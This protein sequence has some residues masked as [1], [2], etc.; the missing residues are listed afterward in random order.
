MTTPSD[1]L[2]TL[3][4]TSESSK[5]Y[6]FGAVVSK[7]SSSLLLAPTS[8][9]FD[10]RLMAKAALDAAEEQ[11]QTLCASHAGTFVAVERRSRKI[12]N[13]LQ[14]LIRSCNNLIQRQ[15]VVAQ[16]KLEQ[17]D[18]GDDEDHES[19]NYVPKNLI[20]ADVDK[21]VLSLAVLSERHRV[22]RR[23]LLQHSSLI[24]LLELPSLMD[25]C[26]RSHLY[27]ESLQIAAFS[28]TLE[29][30]HGSATAST[31]S[32]DAEA[33]VLSKLDNSKDTTSIPTPSQNVV[34]QVIQQIRSR[35]NDLRRH[36]LYRLKSHITMQE[37]LEVV[38]S[39][40]RLDSID[41]ERLNHTDKEKVHKAME[42]RLQI[43]FLEARD[44]WI[45]STNAPTI[46][47]NMAA[48]NSIQRSSL[49]SAQS[50]E[51]FLDAIERYRTR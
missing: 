35:Q 27:E 33:Q 9:S 46:N 37:C 38:T 45:D 29:R 15:S 5:E 21:K 43:D 32:M 22:R 28:N 31:T 3:S 30:R 13:S 50:H 26:I 4:P 18:E 41:L 51:T 14:D 1:P 8:T 42:F 17:S 40:R 34:T 6:G 20:S 10:E 12:E 25:A 19:S 48:G 44:S 7:P 49:L 24:E 23:T 39:L 2:L 47:T 11:L 36:L 16:K